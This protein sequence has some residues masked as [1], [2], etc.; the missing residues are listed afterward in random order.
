[1]AGDLSARRRALRAV[2]HHK[3]PATE[4][5]LYMCLKRIDKE[6]MPVSHTNSIQGKKKYRGWL[7]LHFF[8]H[9]N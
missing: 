2:G 3:S 4:P 1:M 5:P 9:E 7:R 8:R 6:K